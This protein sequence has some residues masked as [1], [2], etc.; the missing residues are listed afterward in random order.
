MGD[1][2]LNL[3]TVSKMHPFFHSA[4]HF[5]YAKSVWL[6][7]QDM[8]ALEQSMNPTEFSRFIKGG[9]TIRRSN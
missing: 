8:A 1:W 3:E 6:Y 7:L 4:G 5:F 9:F 2:K